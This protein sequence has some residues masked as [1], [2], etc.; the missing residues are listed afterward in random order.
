MTVP[1]TA[2]GTLLAIATSAPPV[3]IDELSQPDGLVLVIPH[4]D[5]ET[6]GCGMA[7]SEAAEAGRS[8]GVVL[9]TDGEGSHPQS[10]EYP[11]ER[12]R[13]LRI[14]EFE[15]ALHHLIPRMQ[16]RILRLGKTDGDCQPESLT[17]SDVT[18][19]TAFAT[20]L[21]ASAV[22]STWDQDPH[23]DHASAALLARR[24]ARKIDVP[25]W[26]FAVWGRFG[27]TNIEEARVR[28][29]SSDTA[30][31]RKRAAIQDYRSQMTNLISDDPDGFRM[32]DHL[33][34]HFTEHPEIFIHG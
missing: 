9:L 29:F 5:D 32:P 4:P 19:V 2:S 25:L 10:A 18:A 23:C 8:I 12:L 21:G 28:T 15:K 26:S 6:L 27:Q 22:W 20:S 16:I 30:A 14:T 31:T 3:S 34:K 11:A 7:L 13:K 1:A 17:A 33:V 24:V